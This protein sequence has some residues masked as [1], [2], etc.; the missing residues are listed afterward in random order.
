MKST[1][2][3]RLR[4]RPGERDRDAHLHS[5]HTKANAKEWGAAA[6]AKQCFH[7]DDRGMRVHQG[8]DYRL[9]G[10]DQNTPGW[11]CSDRM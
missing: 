6:N 8:F 9:Q 4:L 11:W 3:F 10:G 7:H 1:K 2:T 5:D